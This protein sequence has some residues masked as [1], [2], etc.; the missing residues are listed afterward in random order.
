MATT[1]SE[2]ISKAPYEEPAEKWAVYTNVPENT[3]PP[4][5]VEERFADLVDVEPTRTDHSTTRLILFLFAEKRHAQRS[6][7]LVFFLIS[8][9]SRVHND[10]LGQDL[11][12]SIILGP[13]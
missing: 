10:Y 5:K 12:Y 11:A 7:F 9:H 6:P 3:A 1:A 2:R 8:G 4:V 13:A